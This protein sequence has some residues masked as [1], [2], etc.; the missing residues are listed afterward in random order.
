MRSLILAAAAASIAA[1]AAPSGAQAQTNGSP[2]GPN[3]FGYGDDYYPYETEFSPNITSN[4]GNGFYGSNCPSP[5]DIDNSLRAVSDDRMRHLVTNGRLASLLLGG[6]E[7]INCGDCFRTFGALGSYSF[8]ANGRFNATERLSVLGGV[9]F[10][11]Y[12]SRGTRTTRAPIFAL[13][14]R[15]D[16]ADWGKSRPFFQ[17][18]GS[19]SLFERTRTTRVVAFNGAPVALRGTTD[20]N[21]WSVH[22]RAG[23]VYRVS[24]VGEF[25]AYVNLS[26]STQRFDSYGEFAAN[27][28]VLPLTYAARSSSMNVIKAVVQHTHLLSSFVELHVSAGLA[29]SFGSRSGLGAVSLEPTYGT[30]AVGARNSTWAEF[31]GRLGFRVAKGVVVDAFALTTVGPKPIG[32]SLHGGLGLRYL[33]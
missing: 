21:T 1:I 18:G 6:T 24:P 8:G 3:C 10:N 27:P 33:F 22:A 16:L 25:A 13:G 28:N 29:H 5:G 14:L 17:V 15:Y 9:S 31:D 11:D 2:N 26:H 7:Q 20:S 19:L 32:N 4:N 30:F 23:W 12:D